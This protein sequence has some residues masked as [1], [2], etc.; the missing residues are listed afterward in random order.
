MSKT[1]KHTSHNSLCPELNFGSSASCIQCTQHYFYALLSRNMNLLLSI[2]W[3]KQMLSVSGHHDGSVEQRRVNHG[4]QVAVA[5]KL[6]TLMTNISG[7][8]LRNVLHVTF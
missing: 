2:N 3:D 7:R 6:Y 4:R 5:S 1:L 8:A